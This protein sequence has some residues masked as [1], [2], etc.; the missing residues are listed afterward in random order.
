MEK[1]R[2]EGNTMEFKIPEENIE[3]LRKKAGKIKRKCEKLGCPFTYEET[4]EEYV[5]VKD[6]DGN[7]VTVRYIIVTAEGRAEVN[8][9]QFVGTVEH[10]EKGNIISCVR[11]EDTG[12]PK[13]YYDSRP[14]CEHCMKKRY[15]KSTF[16]LR[17][18]ESGKYV[19]VGKNCLRDFTGG[20]SVEGVSMYESFIHAAE[21]AQVSNGSHMRPYYDVAE[22]LHYAAET[23]RHFGYV[24]SQSSY[25]EDYD[26]TVRS[27]AQRAFEYWRANHG[28]FR[29][30]DAEYVREIREEMAKV[31]FDET[32]EEAASMTN[33]ALS[34]LDTQPEDKSVYIHNLK[35][36]CG[37]RYTD[38]K[39][40]GL[41]ASLFPAHKKDL[42]IKL[43]RE[44]RAEKEKLSK[45]VGNIGERVSFVPA[46]AEVV[47]SWDTQ[48]GLTML[49]K[50]T[51]EDGNIFIWKTSNDVHEGTSMITGTVKEHSEFRGVKQTVLTRCRQ[52]VKHT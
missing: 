3:K 30:A 15:R 50:I 5:T 6:N 23:I 32:S 45:H 24:R 18:E 8:G 33:D 1:W 35:V 31:G 16:L 36:A 10:T 39:N 13:I 42:E 44:K 25:D 14:F 43:E 41:L 11:G 37:L 21:D 27:T 47:T 29:S 49:W 40:L 28:R 34:W 17:S 38:G 52:T 19:Q 20:M 4:G 7:D 12:I 26:P 51:D 9:W 2:K 48:F 22:W 46:E